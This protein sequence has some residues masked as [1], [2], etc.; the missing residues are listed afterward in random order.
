[1]ATRYLIHVTRVTTYAM[2]SQDPAADPV[3]LFLDC[4]DHNDADE[5]DCETTD[6]RAERQTPRD[7]DNA[8]RCARSL[9]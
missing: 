5:L 2:T 9:R 1:M 7:Y 3:D 8:I 4:A 6:V